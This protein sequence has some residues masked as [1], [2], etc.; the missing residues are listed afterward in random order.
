MDVA[1]PS[2]WLKTTVP[3]LAPVES[4]LRCQVCKDFFDTPMITSCSHTFCSLCIRRCLTNDGKCPVCRTA[5]QELR[6]RRNWTV[7]E[8]VDAFQIARPSLSS[9]AMLE[10][11]HSSVEK[12]TSKRK[13]DDT[14]LE[15]DTD[16][17]IVT[18]QRRK[19]RSHD[20]R[21]SNSTDQATA[22][23]PNEAVQ[24][25]ADENHNGNGSAACPICGQRM[26]EEAVFLHLDTHNEPDAPSQHNLRKSRRAPSV[27]VVGTSRTNVK[28]PERLP[29]LNYSLMKDVALRKKLSE[30]GIPTT[31]PRSLLVR[32]HAEWINIVNANADSSRPKSKRE[33]LRE[34]DIWDR[35]TGR[36]IASSG[37]ELNN[38]GS[39]MRK[40]FDGAAWSANHSSDFQDL[41]SKARNTGRADS[42][43]RKNGS[44][45]N[46]IVEQENHESTTSAQLIDGL[47]ERPASSTIPNSDDT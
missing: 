6:L 45:A 22:P 40:D 3:K 35:S 23:S 2:D 30:L 4:A 18:V 47:P 5:D 10:L 14:D 37:N 17:P 15:E 24:A 27:E 28:P 21:L 32:R 13:L 41:I 36:S 29:Q 7:Q 9:L 43:P 8:I 44:P 42:S 38:A 26:K 20:S 46:V 34:L 1:D 31:G 25:V 39:I 11:N 16:D 33:M 19:T 12:P